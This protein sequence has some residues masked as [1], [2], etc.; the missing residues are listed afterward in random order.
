MR[1]TRKHVNE[2]GAGSTD[3]EDHAVAGIREKCKKKRRSGQTNQKE[4]KGK[5]IRN[6]RKEERQDSRGEV[7]Q[8][9]AAT[10]KREDQESSA[11]QEQKQLKTT[12]V[13]T[14][15][16]RPNKAN[17]VLGEHSVFDSF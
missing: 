17:K 8:R 5:T 7:S 10:E 3:S 1:R 11:R 9:S 4:R 6:N 14:E 2:G 13:Q 15:Q 12:R 16:L